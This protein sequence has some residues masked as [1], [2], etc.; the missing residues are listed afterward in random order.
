MSNLSSISASMKQMGTHRNP[1]HTDISVM[2]AGRGKHGSH[3]M[4]WRTGDFVSRD[5]AVE[6]GES[7]NMRRRLV[8]Y[9]L[10]IKSG[11]G[12]KQAGRSCTF[13]VRLDW[14]TLKPVWR[15]RVTLRV[16]QL[17]RTQSGDKTYD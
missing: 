15:V 8:P 12:K 5:I 16:A 11:G 1:T 13:F 3:G 9:R 7:S 17:T 4:L 6:S 2:V 10:E 14:G